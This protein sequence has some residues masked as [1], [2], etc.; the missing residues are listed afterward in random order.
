MLFK[1]EGWG[2]A[3]TH[4]ITITFSAALVFI[5]V[6][7]WLYVSNAITSCYE[8]MLLFYRDYLSL[9]PMQ[10]RIDALG[11]FAS[12]PSFV[13]TVV[14]SLIIIVRLVVLKNRMKGEGLTSLSKE[15]APFGPR[16]LSLIVTNLVAA[17]LILAVTVVPGRTDDHLM[18]QG[19]VCLA[20]PLAYV[21]NLFVRSF[22]TKARLQSLLGVVLIA[23]LGLALVLPSITVTVGRAQE[24]R[25]GTPS[26]AVQQELVEAVQ[27]YLVVDEPIIVFGD[28]CW[29]YTA[30]DTYSATRYPYQPFDATFRPDLNADFFRQVGVAEAGLLVSRV[31][32]GAIESY[33][34]IGDYQQVF[35]NTR[36]QVY[37]F[38]PPPEDSSAQEDAAAQEG[39]AAQGD[40]A[41]Q[42]DAAAQEGTASQENATT[43]EDATEQPPAQ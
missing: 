5:V 29:I 37:L 33:P 15:D 34:G 32:D 22:L 16:T 2:V 38:T 23:I 10:T 17:V 27:R 3:L 4:L 1:K 24:Q 25:M 13:L 41:S 42:Q 6:I 14:I 9:V 36:Y 26:L 30:A 40:G 20:I 31:G 39:A 11:Y 19:L 12:Q 7:P 35:K 8:Q 18:L 21:L 28:D 43:Q